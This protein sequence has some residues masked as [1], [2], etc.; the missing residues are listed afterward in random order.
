[1]IFTARWFQ[2]LVVVLVTMQILELEECVG[3]ATLTRS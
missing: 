2:S 1:M 3:F